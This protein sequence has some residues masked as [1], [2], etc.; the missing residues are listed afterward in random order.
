MKD[1]STFCPVLKLSWSCCPKCKAVGINKRTNKCAASSENHSCDTQPWEW[2]TSKWMEKIPTDRVVERD[3]RWD[4]GTVREGLTPGG[5]GWKMPSFFSCGWLCTA[6]TRGIIP[7]GTALA[8]SLATG[9]ILISLGSCV[10]AGKV[11]KSVRNK[12]KMRILMIFAVGFLLRQ[13]ATC[14]PPE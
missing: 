9:Q 12:N 7:Q 1:L 11:K 4:S 6:M 10:E 3:H 5:G 2:D 8:G 13:C 14:T